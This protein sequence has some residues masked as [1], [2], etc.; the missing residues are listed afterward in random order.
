MVNDPNIDALFGPGKGEYWSDLPHALDDEPSFWGAYPSD[1]VAY[2][3]FIDWVLI[4]AGLYDRDAPRL[5]LGWGDIVT[6]P[7]GTLDRFPHAIIDWTSRS[8]YS[9]V[10][11]GEL[12][13]SWIDPDCLHLGGVSRVREDTRVRLAKVPAL[14]NL[15]RRELSFVTRTCPTWIE[16]PADRDESLY[17]RLIAPLVDLKHTGQD[18]LS[19]WLALMFA[20]CAGQPVAYYSTYTPSEHIV[21]LAQLSDVELI[22]IPLSALPEALLAR[23]HAYRSMHLGLSQWKEL[24]RRMAAAGLWQEV[25]VLT[26]HREGG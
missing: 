22:H 3:E 18:R 10:L 20:F 17:E 4:L 9:P 7:F 13:G 2:K 21:S 19:S 5:Q 8:E 15:E 11:T 16:D 26:A 1:E 12:P 6:A 24:E 25:G 23:N 14:V